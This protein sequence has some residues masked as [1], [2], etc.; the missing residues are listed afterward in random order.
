MMLLQKS[1]NNWLA[2]EASLS[3][4]VKIE[5]EL[6]EQSKEDVDDQTKLFGSAVRNV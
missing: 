4:L 1:K 6:L 5:E 2:K 3:K